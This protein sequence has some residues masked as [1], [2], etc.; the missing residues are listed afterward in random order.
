MTQ[1][2]GLVI[3]SAWSIFVAI[4]AVLAY[5]LLRTEKDPCKKFRR[6][7]LTSRIRRTPLPPQKASQ[8][9]AATA[10]FLAPPRSLRQQSC[11]LLTA[12]F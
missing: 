8:A 5:V 1:T 6:Q 11:W 3:L 4:L 7:P 10:D 9:P 12:G 2:G